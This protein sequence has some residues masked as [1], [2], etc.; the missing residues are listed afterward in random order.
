MTNKLIQHTSTVALIIALAVLALIAIFP[1]NTQTTEAQIQRTTCWDRFVSAYGS[2]PTTSRINNNAGYEGF[3]VFNGNNKIMHWFSKKDTLHYYYVGVVEECDKNG[4][5]RVIWVWSNNAWVQGTATTF[6][7]HAQ[8]SVSMPNQVQAETPRLVV[9]TN[10][11][12]GVYHINARIENLNK[13]NK[14][15][16]R[17]LIDG[18]TIRNTFYRNSIIRDNEDKFITI[19]H[20]A[21]TKGHIEI[22]ENNAEVRVGRV[23]QTIKRE[24][25]RI[26]KKLT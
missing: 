4:A 23:W 17:L 9:E 14:K 1:A 22:D 24:L 10:N 25:I 20:Q 26:P 12:Q 6:T 2:Y 5:Q 18:E 16:H 7:P 13:D 21:L 11:I 3:E 19:Q 8:K 15:D